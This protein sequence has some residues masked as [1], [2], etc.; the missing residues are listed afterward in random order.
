[1]DVGWVANNQCVIKSK[2][3]GAGLMVSGFFEEHDRFLRLTQ[4]EMVQF[5]K[6]P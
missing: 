1:M 2:S 6:I 3:Q 5:S 4:E